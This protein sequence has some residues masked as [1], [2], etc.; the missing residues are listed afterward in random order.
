MKPKLHALLLVASLIATSTAQADM[1]ACGSAYAKDSLDDQIRLYTLCLTQGGVGRQNLAGAF[2]G[3]GVAY[4]RK[5]DVDQAMR[6]FD[7]SIRLDPD[8]GLTYFIRG[9]ANLYRGQL[10]LAEA[11]MS[12]SI[13]RPMIR[14]KDDLYAY[15]GLLRMARG[16]CAVALEDFDDAIK[17]NRKLAWAYGAKAWVLST[18][19]GTLEN[20][21]EEA[22]KLAQSALSL[23]DHW[24]FHDALAAAY[25]EAGRFA[26]SVRELQLA[27]AQIDA[28]KPDSPWR[29]G[30][31][32]RLALYQAGKPYREVASNK[33]AAE[34]AT[35]F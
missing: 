30:L 3:R 4:Y 26:D 17:R 28:A 1:S 13:K 35:E 11:D 20:S 22:I 34:W 25:A 15:R 23:Q 10:D 5:G 8:Y 27:Q 18:C 16:N 9:K 33:V 31:T 7:N 21:G 6:D 19:G 32:E 14:P 2:A 29:T 24:K 12:A